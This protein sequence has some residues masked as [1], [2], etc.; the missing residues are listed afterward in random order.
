MVNEQEIFSIEIVHRGVESSGP[1]AGSQ[2][3]SI[4][5]H[6]KLHDFFHSLDVMHVKLGNHYLISNALYFLSIP[7]LL[8]MIEAIRKNSL[9]KL[10]EHASPDLVRLMYVCGLI[11][12]VDT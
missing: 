11:G 1:N 12:F 5:V 8:V 10:W 3:F 9:W 4:R 6:R 7:L 2:R